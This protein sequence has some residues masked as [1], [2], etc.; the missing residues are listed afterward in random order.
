MPFGAR[1]R[2]RRQRRFRLWAPRRAAAWSWFASAAASRRPCRCSALRDGWFEAAVRR[3]DAGARY[4]FRIDGDLVVPDPASRCN[5]DD[6]HGASELIDPLAFDWPDAGWRG[7][8]WHE[9]VVYELHV[10][11]FTPEGT[12]AAAIERLDDLVALG[13]TAIE[14]MP[15]ADFPGRR[16]W[17]YD[18]V[19]LFAPE[20]SLRHARR[21]EA[22]GR[23]GARARPDGA[24]RRGLQPLRPRRQLPARLRAGTSSTPTRP[25]PGARR[26]TSTAR[27]AARCATSSSTTRCTGSRSS[28]ST[29]CASTRC[30][31][32]TT[33]RTLH[34]V[35]ELAQAVR[36]GPGRERQVHLVLE[37][38]LNDAA[39]PA[40]RRGRAAPAGRRAVERRRAPRPARAGHRRDRRLLRRLRR[41]SRSACSAA[42]WPRASPTRAT[43]RPTAT[44]S[45][46]ARR[47]RHLPPLAFVNSCRPTT[48]SATAPSASASAT[49]AAAAGRNDAL[50]AL[51]ACVLLSP[52]PPM[53]FMGEE[54]AASTP[55]LFFCD[56]ERRSG[57]GR[58]ARAGAPSSAASRASPTRPCASASP[59]R[60]P[61]QHL[62]RQQARL[63]RARARAACALAGAVPRPAAPAPREPGALAGRRTQRHADPARAGHRAHPLATG[64]GPCLAPAGPARRPRRYVAGG[65]MP[66]A[67][68]YASHA[69]GATT[70]APWSVCVSLEHA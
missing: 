23:R 31:R 12:F 49:L 65:S 55:F 70:L 33:A 60:T 9:A 53:L 38:D 69:A 28:T 19:L 37:N 5:P 62:Q 43:P 39:P 4:A 26:S 1:R 44:A 25:R 24:A 35:D 51:T 32:C 47:R 64:A 42:R 7:R 54:W 56:F 58:H 13:I 36:N 20:A 52:S 41:P 30:T 34:F 22:A 3:A 68:V 63:E 17:G 15:V 27:T 14:L 67:L 61:R 40:A 8:P 45:R 48:R 21:P 57:R 10:G 29:A 18:G 16:G 66:G 59:T 2:R 50:R 46:A 6:V 11:S